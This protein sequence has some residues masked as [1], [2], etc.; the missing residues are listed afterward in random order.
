MSD[1]S[2]DPNED[3]ARLNEAASCPDCKNIWARYSNAFCARHSIAG[4]S[5]RD[6]IVTSYLTANRPIKTDK[7]KGSVAKPK[8][9]ITKQKIAESEL[10]Q[11]SETATVPKWLKT[12][13]GTIAAIFLLLLGLGGCFAALEAL[14]IY[15]PPET[16]DQLTK[17][18]ESPKTST[19]MP[20]I[21][22]K[23]YTQA[24]D[25]LDEICEENQCEYYDLILT[26]SVWDSSNWRVV[27]QAP[28]AGTPVEDIYLVC[29]GIVKND[30]LSFQRNYN[31]PTAC[32]KSNS[33]AVIEREKSWIPDG[34]E[35]DFDGFAS[36]GT[37]R[38][39]DCK[40]EGKRGR[41]AYYQYVTRDGLTNGAFVKVQWLNSLNEVVDVSLFTTS[42]L[43]NPGG[44]FDFFAFLP[45]ST[46]DK[47]VSPRILDISG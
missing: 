16:T 28:P 36:D 23:S 22:G 8:P 40:F 29:I 9:A 24:D 46:W 30:E 12:V 21:T 27:D 19:F 44:K 25:L 47:P 4:W 15:T 33:E 45:N 2:L 6:E 14:G 26:R 39:E 10:K 17:S 31:L 11:E 18:D 20:S 7:Q 5:K 41:C 43:V 3:G 32:P 35:E 34:Y 1:K 38:F 13:G 37:L 42:G